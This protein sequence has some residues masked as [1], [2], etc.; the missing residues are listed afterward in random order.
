M[1]SIFERFGSQAAGSLLKSIQPSPTIT[2]YAKA[3]GGLLNGD[4]SGVASGAM[5]SY[6]GGY[7]SY[8]NS[9]R[10]VALAGA[11]W[12]TLIAMFEESQNVLRERSNL[13][14]LRVE[15]IGDVAAPRINLLA[16]EVSY[17]GVQLGYDTKKIGSGFTQAPT[18]LDPIEVNITCYDVD[19]EIKTWFE[20]LKLKHA[21]PDGTFGLPTEY[22]NTFT[23]THGAIEEGRGYAKTMVLV[24]GTLQAALNRE[25]D[26]FSA[27]NLTFHEY[28]SFG[29]I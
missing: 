16:T 3:L 1:A 11:N 18:G 2:K 23:I 5:D 29:A 21:R 17:N 27:L 20:N 19:G 22:A 25:L 9:A 12:G 15:P 24:P 10:D 6:F 4:F 26:E 14:F 7:S 8:G 13:W 28:E